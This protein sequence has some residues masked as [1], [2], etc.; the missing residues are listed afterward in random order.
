M[1]EFVILGLSLVISVG[2][3]LAAVAQDGV[4]RISKEELRAMQGSPELI[5]IDVRS[6]RDWESSDMKIRGA[7][8]EDPMNIPNWIRK[9]PPEKILVFYCA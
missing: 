9:Y 6:P 2:A 5:I 4:P 3:V 7:V 8:R 1:Q